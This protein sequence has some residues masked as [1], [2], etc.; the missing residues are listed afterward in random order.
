MLRIELS[1]FFGDS[2]FVKETSTMVQRFFLILIFSFG[3]NAQ[4]IEE[5]QIQEVVVTATR[6]ERKLR[7]VPIAT[8][9]IPSEKIE[10]ANIVNFKDF[11]KQE[12][13][14]FN[15]ENHSNSPNINMLGLGAKYILFLI[16]GERMAG[17]TFDNIDYNRININDIERVEIVKGASSSLY[18]SDAIAGVINIV[19]KKAKQ[20]L[21]AQIL[22][23]YGSFN[24][25]NG[26]IFL[27]SKQKWGSV[28]VSAFYKN[29][30]PYLLHDKAPMIQVYDNGK[31]IEN[32][33]ENTIVA[34]FFDYGFNPKLSLKISPKI[35]LDLSSNYYFKERNTGDANAQKLREQYTDFSNTG[36]LNIRFSNDERLSLS[37]NYGVYDKFDRYLLL[38][39]KNKTYENTIGRV[40]AI[41]DRKISPR[42]SLILGGDFLTEGLNSFMFENGKENAQTYSVFAQKEWALNPKLTLLTG[43]RYDYHSEYKGHLTLRLSGMYRLG[44]KITLRGGYAEG[45]RSP[46]LKELYTDWFHPYG[47][48]FH[49]EGNK[50][51]KVEKS[52]NFNL[53]ADAYY[54]K[55]KLNMM[56]QYSIIRNKIET[57]W[58]GEARDIL[59]YANLEKARVFSTEFS[60]LYNIRDNFSL[61]GGYAFAYDFEKQQQQ[62]RPHM[63]TARMEFSP[64]VFGN[65]TPTFSFSGKFFSGVDIWGT[66]QNLENY[67]VHYNP[68]SLWRFGVNANLPKSVQISLGIDNVFDYRPQY[69]SFY[70]TSSA[71]RTYFFSLKWNTKK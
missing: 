41:Y 42:H 27:G 38:N 51:L 54:D 14:G 45:F 28:S 49:I 53:S 26:N 18:G 43:G 20:K 15:F 47:G 16:D 3:V 36:K 24:E 40:S 35:Q 65:F 4:N 17:E 22:A 68:Y 11:L 61:N 2:V 7:E 9:I 50:N 32:Q 37:A 12:L 69:Y 5:T 30:D 59:Q 52:H 64:K 44:E 23:R 58:Q 70:T 63:I 25:F 33:L 10:K 48:G 31:V 8:T 71:G 6:T 1:S 67:K 57:L 34:G 60:V 21:E 29:R 39:S 46:T 19:T 13:A 55:L 56:S 66:D 62:T